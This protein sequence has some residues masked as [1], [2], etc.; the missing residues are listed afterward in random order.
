M[1]EGSIALSRSLGNEP[2]ID[3]VVRAGID[4]DVIYIVFPGSGD[5]TPQTPAAIRGK[6]KA[7]FNALGGKDV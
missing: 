2:L 4:N 5:G 1:G 6:G 3:E 7:L